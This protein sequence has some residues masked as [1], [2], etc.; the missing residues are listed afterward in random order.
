MCGIPLIG[1]PCSGISTALTLLAPVEKLKLNIEIIRVKGLL[2]GG[3]PGFSCGLSL[4]Y[5]C[6][7]V[8]GHRA[9]SAF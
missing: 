5:P 6:V 3:L 4:F 9:E 2:G 8:C 7:C 1:Q